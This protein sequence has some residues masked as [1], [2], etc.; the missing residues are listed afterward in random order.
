MRKHKIKSK[1]TGL[2]HMAYYVPPGREHRIYTKEG[3][4]RISGG[5]VVI[6]GNGGQ[7][8][9]IS[10]EEM[11]RDYVAIDRNGF[12]GPGPAFQPKPPGLK[13]DE[14]P[15]K[16]PEETTPAIPCRPTDDGSEPV[17]SDPIIPG[18]DDI[19]REDANALDAATESQEPLDAGDFDDKG[20]KPESEDIWGGS[21]E[22]DAPNA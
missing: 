8:F 17:P 11:H 7:A 20:L 5:I 10:V 6:N 22:P 16:F 18:Q 4:R 9:N 15:A 12:P 14:I 1:I 13:V 19:D 3:A 21:D 2:T